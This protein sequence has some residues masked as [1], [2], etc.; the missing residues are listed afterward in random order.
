[1]KIFLSGGLGFLGYYTSKE[2]LR[3]GHEVTAYDAYLNYIDPLK[4]NYSAHLDHRIRDLGDKVRIIRGDTRNLAG[5]ISSLKEIQP[6]VVIQLAAIPLAKA[7]NQFSEDAIQINLNGTITLLEAIRLTPSVRRVVFASSSFV[8]G[9][10][11]YNPADEEHPTEPIDVYGGTK[12]AGEALIKGF[13]RRF[14][15]EFVIIRPSAVYGPTDANRRVTQIFVENSLLG[16]PLILHDG[17]RS[18]VD[19]TYCEDT[20]HGIVLAA[21]HPAATNK[22]FNI[23][24]GEGRSIKE[25]AEIISRLV[26]GTRIDYRTADETRP[27]RG[28]MEINM[29]RKLLGYE[30]RFS[31]EEG[32]ERYIA[33]VQESGV[34]NC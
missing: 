1:M 17:G 4:S 5:L 6:E 18:Q 13:S 29:A 10:F 15:I 22:V 20:A 2:L 23:T 31:L 28:A 27:E 12:L 3:Q 33:F 8:Y 32:M 14:D 30:P 9:N 19:F 7:S 11:L 16:K 21:L 25:L 34:L 24:R 26:P